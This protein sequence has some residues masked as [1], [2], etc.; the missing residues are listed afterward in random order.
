[1]KLNLY[2]HYIDNVQCLLLEL[3]KTYDCGVSYNESKNCI[4]GLYR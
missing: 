2:L 1:M 3:V 4:A